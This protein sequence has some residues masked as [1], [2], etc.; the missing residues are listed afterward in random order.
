MSYILDALKKAER[1]RGISKVPTLETVHDSQSV[2]QIRRWIIPGLFILC[3]AVILWL[4]LF[5]LRSKKDP[6]SLHTAESVVPVQQSVAKEI[7]PAS[8][9]AAPAVITQTETPA[10][11]KPVTSQETPAQKTPVAVIPAPPPAQAVDSR[12]AP[13]AKTPEPAQEPVGGGGNPEVKVRPSSATQE[14][15]P[16]Q[17]KPLNQ[18]NPLPIRAAIASMTM[19]IHSF[20]DVQAERFVFINGKKYSEGD[21]VDGYY[22]IESI[23]PE[24]AVLS[25]EGIRATLRQGGR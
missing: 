18:E 25:Y 6:A 4:L 22:R 11:A 8:A 9:K 21:Y 3:A 16:I 14:K 1:E 10:P 7:A 2:P 5:P 23:T 24:G 19:T 15:P 12:P 17:E 20:S 13:A